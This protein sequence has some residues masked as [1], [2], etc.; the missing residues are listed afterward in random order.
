MSIYTEEQRSF[1]ICINFIFQYPVSDPTQLKYGSLSA[2]PLFLL[3]SLL[4]ECPVSAFLQASLCTQRLYHHLLAWRPLDVAWQPAYIRF[5]TDLIVP[6]KIASVCMGFL[7]F[8]TRS[9]QKMHANVDVVWTRPQ[10]RERWEASLA[11]PY[12]FL[13]GRHFLW[14]V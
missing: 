11:Q 5:H 6:S 14:S 4:Q 9:R 2:A 12:F 8:F 3:R 7:V 13:I 1:C 10:R